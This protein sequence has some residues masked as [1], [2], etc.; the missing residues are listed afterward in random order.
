MTSVRL[1]MYARTLCCRSTPL[2]RRSRCRKLQG[3]TKLATAGSSQMAAIRISMPM[4]SPD[5][6]HSTHA[7]E[8]VEQREHRVQI[9]IRIMSVF[10]EL[11]SR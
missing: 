5:V 8:A 2:I 1:I 4:T 7:A 6:Q 11:C 9:L 10:P 3:P